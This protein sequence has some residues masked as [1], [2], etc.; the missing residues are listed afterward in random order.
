MVARTSLRLN[1]DP[2]HPPAV[3]RDRFA[4]ALSRLTATVCVVAATEADGTRHGRTATAVMSLAADPPTMLVS[5]DR[6][7]AMAGVIE[8]TEGFSVAMLAEDQD[9]VAD[10]FAGKLAIDRSERFSRG[11]WSAWPS[12]RPKLEGAVAVVDCHLI[13]LTE[14]STHILF[15]GLVTE[16]ET[17]D[18]SPLLWSL[19][20]YAGVAARRA[21]TPGVDED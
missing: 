7:S 11:T 14:V 13:G 15:V 5:I 18:A 21:A 2:R 12:G 4:E 20:R 17:L 10:A 8:T 3:P 1:P 6:T 19:R 16:V 9:E